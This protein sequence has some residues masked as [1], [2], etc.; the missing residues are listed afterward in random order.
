VLRTS[1]AFALFSINIYEFAVKQSLNQIN[2]AEHMR[3]IVMRMSWGFLAAL[4]FGLGASVAM[5]D[6]VAS[7]DL[8]NGEPASL[9]D[10]YKNDFYIGTCLGG[11]LTDSYSAD[12]IGMIVKQ[13]NA[14]TP[15]NCMKPEPIHPT[16]AN[17]NWEEADALV[18]FAHDHHMV[19]YGHTLVWHN[20]TPQWFFK[21]G[22]K[23]AS[24]ELLLARLK[25][26]IQTEV[27]RYKGKLRAWDVVNEAIPDSGSANLR[28]SNWD[29]IIGDDF[30]EYAFQYAHE[31]DPDAGLQYNDYNI[32]TGD[33]F[34]KALRLLKKLKAE[35]IPITSVGIQGHWLL[36][37]VPLKDIE[38]AIV[39]FGALGLK[40]NITEL[41]IDVLPRRVAGGDLSEI[42]RPGPTTRSGPLA[43]PALADALKRQAAQY[44][45]LFEML[46][47]HHDLMDRVTFWGAD[48]GH[49]WL[50]G[51][52][53][54]NYPLVFDRQLQ[55][56]PAFDAI[57]HALTISQNF[58]N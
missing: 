12:E 37:R 23:P 17:W 54:N 5:A 31:A 45:Q 2:L 44:G 49:S 10:V 1:A 52:R 38:N 19:V 42:N 30:I 15:E 47:R 32:E 39:A 13:Y 40:V 20:Q 8:I 26:H 3:R 7:Q 34:Q 48:D 50:N 21:D 25:T 11:K 4:F 33:K 56:K 28:K 55:P 22:D 9:K 16:E 58:Q 24:K 18:R 27:G 41:D 43:G 53:G 46:H 6:S 57:I 35:N 36:D 51:R 14:V 29:K